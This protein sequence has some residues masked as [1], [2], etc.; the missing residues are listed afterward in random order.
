MPLF[1]EIQTIAETCGA[2]F[3]GVADLALAH[4]EIVRQGGEEI[5][6]YPRAISLGIVLPHAIVDQ[7]PNRD[8]PAVAALYL[9]HAYAVINDRL[10]ALASLVAGWVQRRGYAALPLTVKE[11]HDNERIC[12]VFSHKLA[13]HLAGFGW[14]GKSCLLITPQAGPRVRWVSV[15]TDAPLAATGGPMAPRCGACRECVDAC[16]VGAFT[17]EPFR[18]ED[19]REVRYD[20]KKCQRYFYELH[21]AGKPPACGMCVYACPHGKQT[22]CERS[23]PSGLDAG[24]PL[25]LN[26]FG[27]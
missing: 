12:A 10:D 20:A 24:A 4:E 9:H 15:L 6:K 16:P 17:G 18:P 19:P 5:G 25:K 8:D 13:A 2:E 26:P 3:C 27:A 23:V 11:H 7:L 22:R 21:Q 14:I 1:N